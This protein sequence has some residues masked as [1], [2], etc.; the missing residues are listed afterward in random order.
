ME[1]IY[2]KR[3]RF[4]KYFFIFLALGLGI[5]VYLLFRSRNLFYYNFIRYT[6][7]AN[8]VDKSRE[9]AWRYRS[10]IPN[11]VIYS[12][13]D[14]LWIFALGIAIMY[15]KYSY[16]RL[17]LLYGIM[18]GSVILME[19]IQGWFGGHGTF[20]GT[21]DADDVKCY[22]YG[23]I[24]ASIFACIS[25]CRHYKGV[26]LTNKKEVYKKEL[27]QTLILIVIFTIIAFFPAL[28]PTSV[29]QKLYLNFIWLL[30][31]LSIIA[32]DSM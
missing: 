22:I 11:W 15:N 18:F 29:S 31:K 27:I 23:F 28:I 20:L 7:F 8:G 6:A 1:K 13:P 21:F 16:W 12:L 10:S 24:I 25:W 14:G 17:Q 30:D 2:K 26:I 5:T 4:Y 3:A 32:R 19:C 9:I